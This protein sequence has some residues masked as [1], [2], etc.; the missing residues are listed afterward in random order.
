MDWKKASEENKKS[1]EAEA[2]KKA[3]AANDE[4]TLKEGLGDLFNSFLN[5]IEL[6]LQ[7]FNKQVPADHRVEHH[8]ETPTRL[9]LEKKQSFPNGSA[10][11][12]LDRTAH[13]I[14]YTH[15]TIPQNVGLMGPVRWEGSLEIKVVDGQLVLH[16]GYQPLAI[17]ENIIEEILGQWLREM[18]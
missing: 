14:N 17:D 2:D 3:A 7:S 13:R 1:R 8:L 18:A 16:R 5:Q 15:V 6:G 11:L 10:T 9:L 4:K 12:T